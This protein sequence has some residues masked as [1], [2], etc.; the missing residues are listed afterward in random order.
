MNDLQKAQALLKENK[1][2]T[3]VFVCGEEVKTSE[4]RGV[5]PLL[6]LIGENGSLKGWSAADKVVGRAAA[7][8][9][10]YLGVDAVFAE[11][12]SKF[13]EE[14][15]LAHGIAYTYETFTESI[16]NRKGDGPCP[17]EQATRGILDP[18]EGLVAVR[19]K[20]KELAGP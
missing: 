17:M 3:C 14:V 12:L 11:V 18:E 5:R 7:L 1:S 4:L 16:V 15:F 9:Y 19:K 20:L 6:E 2:L 13:A 10:A 8:L